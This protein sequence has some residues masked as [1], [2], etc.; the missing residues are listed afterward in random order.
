VSARVEVLP[1]ALEQIE[2]AAAWWREHREAS[3]ELFADELAAAFTLLAEQPESG[4]PL[5]RPRFP[6]LRVLLMPRTRHHVY[7][8]HDAGAGVVLVR[9]LWGAVRGRRPPLRRQ[10]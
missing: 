9:A 5:P 3:P 6:R 10:H 7:Y 4:R 1:D 8:E 2:Q